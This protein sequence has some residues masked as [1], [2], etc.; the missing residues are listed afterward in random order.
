MRSKLPLHGDGSIV[1]FHLPLQS[2]NAGRDLSEFESLYPLEQWRL[3]S[4]PI[5]TLEDS[6]ETSILVGK[7][8]KLTAI[9]NNK[10]DYETVSRL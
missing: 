5:A 8:Q 4:C 6:S 9:N 10:C 1:T 7:V 3:T 2:H